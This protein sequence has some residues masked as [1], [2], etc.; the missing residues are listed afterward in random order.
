MI[1]CH[2]CIK[3]PCLGE[4]IGI[5]CGYVKKPTRPDYAYKTIEEYEKIGRFRVNE[6]FKDGW[7]MA[8]VTMDQLRQLA[9]NSGGIMDDSEK[10]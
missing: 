6:A 1:K 5:P 8:R 4:E 10:E 3:G 2:E 7:M 9:R